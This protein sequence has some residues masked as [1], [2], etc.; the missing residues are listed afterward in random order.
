M[1]GACGLPGPFALV[2]VERTPPAEGAALSALDT[3]GPIGRLRH[4][5]DG[6]V[7]ERMRRCPAP[8]LDI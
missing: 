7:A 5:H 6:D 8:Y 1:E 2:C 4:M 3:V